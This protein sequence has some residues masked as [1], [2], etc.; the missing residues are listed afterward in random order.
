MRLLL[1]PA[2]SFI[3]ATPCGIFFVINQTELLLFFQF[4]SLQGNK[5]IHPK[6]LYFTENEK[7]EV[8]RMNCDIC[9]S[10]K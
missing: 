2:V 7:V 1:Y 3:L 6:W 4:T 8:V 10:F 9:C 5:S